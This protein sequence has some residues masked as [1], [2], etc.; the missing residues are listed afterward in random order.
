MRSNKIFKMFVVS[1]MIAVLAACSSANDNNES[2][3][4]KDA[5]E[6]TIDMGQINWAENIAVTNMWKVILAEHG[7]DVEF[8]VLDIGTTM[9]ALANDELDIGMEIWLPIQDASYLENYQDKVDF[10]E[11]TWYDNA[12]VGLVVPDY[13][14]IDSVEELN[15]HVDLFEGEIVGFDPGAGTMEVTEDLLDEYDLNFELLPSSEPAM[16][17]EIKEAIKNEE[18]IV[19]PLW[20]PHRIFSEVDLKYLDDPKEVYGGVEKIHHAT[21]HGFAEDYP[22]VDEWFKNWKMDDDDIGSL[23]S[24]VAEAED[25]I[26]GAT[27]W[28]EEN[29][30]VIA[31][32][33]NE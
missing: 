8:H 15:D 1:I 17:T 7:Y 24:Y 31:E 16:I 18:P 12:R 33:I 27:K 26:D 30:D 28:V 19:S 9:E 22:E 6:K 3:G 20:S 2:S 11:E 29:E 4:N 10:S 14:D 25:P 32:W 21:R 23:M 13:V 5:D